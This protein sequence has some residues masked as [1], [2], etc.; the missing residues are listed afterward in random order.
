MND[1]VFEQE[2]ISTWT[3]DP[4][5]LIPEAVREGRFTFPVEVLHAFH[6]QGLKLGAIVKEIQA[7][8]IV[9]GELE[10]IP[11]GEKESFAIVQ[12]YDEN[13]GGALEPPVFL[14]PGQKIALQGYGEFIALST[15]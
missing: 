4:K 1:S 9:D 6:L 2:T 14:K 15:N 5:D 13:D 8:T 12:R 11:T 3:F 10:F 7:T